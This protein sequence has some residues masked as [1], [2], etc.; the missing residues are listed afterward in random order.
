MSWRTRIL[1]KSRINPIVHYRSQ[2]QERT[3]QGM[4]RLRHLS[5]EGIRRQWDA[6][7][8]H[9]PLSKG[10]RIV[11]SP[12]KSHR[13]ISLQQLFMWCQQSPPKTRTKA[14]SSLTWGRA[15]HP[16]GRLCTST[17][18]RCRHLS[19]IRVSLP[20]TRAYRRCSYSLFRPITITIIGCICWIRISLT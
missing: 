17:H 20:L 5:L 10:S 4:E 19:F 15:K 8:G 11:R 3:C 12:I 16:T 13:K 2:I 7:R 14:T 9:S 1:S 18:Q 6:K